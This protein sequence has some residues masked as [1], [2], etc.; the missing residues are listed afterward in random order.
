M[1]S[2]PVLRTPWA[3]EKQASK[4]YT[5]K[6]FNIFQEEVIA[7]RDHCSVL[8]TTQEAVKYIIVGDGSMR[9]RVVQWCTEDI[10]GRCSCK[11]FEKMGITCR[12]IIL[13]LRGE[14]IY[15]LPSSYILKRWE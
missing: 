5:H 9:D 2:T 13:T 11:L 10:F 14:K 4:L 15:E 12:H 7:A 8:E 6:V 3:V 1:H